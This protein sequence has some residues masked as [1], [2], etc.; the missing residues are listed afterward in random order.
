M[1]KFQ[2]KANASGQYYFP[3][4]VRQELGDK[5]NL[6]CDTKAAIVFSED[7]MLQ[8]VLESIEIIARDLQHRLKLQK[9]N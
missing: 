5:I 1:V 9:E 6:I 3:K 4:E 2:V 7:A 8:N